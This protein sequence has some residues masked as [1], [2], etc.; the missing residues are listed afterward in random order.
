[1]SY[2]RATAGE[3]WRADDDK[4]R[5]V[6]Q[7]SRSKYALPIPDA[8]LRAASSVADLGMWMAIGE[9]WA[10]VSLHFLPNREPVVVDIGCG[11]GKMARFLLAHPRLRYI[12]L[13]VYEPA[14]VWSRSA[15]EPLYGNRA[16]FM[17]LDVYSELYNPS[18]QVSAET[19]ELPFDDG[20]LDFVICGSLFTHLLESEMDRYLAEISRVLRP[21]GRM[22]A[23]IHNEPAPGQTFSG[24]VLRIDMTNER[25]LAGCNVA[26]LIQS[27]YVGNLYG[28]HAF[29]VT[30]G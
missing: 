24:D 5:A 9:A 27:V 29:V 12:G 7:R 2:V 18:G 6:H 28:Q 21:G 3:H 26:G 15:F 19:V 8:G 23:S 16:R 4:D 14:I 17:R 11:C 22:L 13:D 10:Q 30:R 20:S 1:M 25:F